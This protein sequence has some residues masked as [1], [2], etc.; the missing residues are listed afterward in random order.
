MHDNYYEDRMHVWE[1]RERL[2]MLTQG[3]DFLLEA[4]ERGPNSEFVP[5]LEQQQAI[6]RLRLSE[7][8]AAADPLIDLP[9]EMPPF[10]LLE[11]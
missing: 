4:R 5:S 6:G 2:G 9:P 7:E 11:D 10:I 1:I 3:L 8:E